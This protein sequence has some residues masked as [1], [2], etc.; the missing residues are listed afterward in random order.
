M[1]RIGDKQK[2]SPAARLVAPAKTP[3]LPEQI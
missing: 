2:R 1:L 3:H